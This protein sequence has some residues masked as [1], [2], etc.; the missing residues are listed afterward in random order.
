M[1][2]TTASAFSQYLIDLSRLRNLQRIQAG[3]TMV[4][5]AKRKQAVAEI[6]A[7]V[8]H[9]DELWVSMKDIADAFKPV[10]RRVSSLRP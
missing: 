3:A 5:P 2:N 7:L 6:P 1:A 8:K 4:A 10:H 9:L